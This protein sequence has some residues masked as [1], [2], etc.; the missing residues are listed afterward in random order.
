MRSVGIGAALLAG[1]VACSDDP[2]QFVVR[3]VEVC[4]SNRRGG[5]YCIDVY[6]A[7]R[8][9]ATKDSGG[10]DDTAPPM[11]LAERMPWTGI[12]WDGARQACTSKGKRL[13]DRAEWID[14]C[15]GAVGEDE[16]LEHAYGDDVDVTR[17]NTEGVGPESSG[18]RSGC[19]S[20]AGTFD[21]SGNVWEWTG[22]TQGLA[23]ARGGG[24]PSSAQHKCTSGDTM[25][26]YGPTD[27]SRQLGFRCC[28]D[29]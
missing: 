4:L 11:S 7:S 18:A 26:I 22:N 5:E 12:S 19:L 28:R 16:G 13:C 24:Y 27:T 14:A 9:D 10:V 29:L 23:S 25:V 17:C 20:P 3:D 21:Q 6:E 15:D 8:R 1:C 2:E